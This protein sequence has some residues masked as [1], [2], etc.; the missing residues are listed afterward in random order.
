MRVLK[1]HL[2]EASVA[3]LN[4]IG[5]DS[6]TICES[7]S[8][9]KVVEPGLFV[10]VKSHDTNQWKSSAQQVR[11]YIDRLV[12]SD[13]REFDFDLDEIKICS[14]K[15]TAKPAATAIILA[16]GG[17]GRIGLDKSM[18]LINGKPIIECVY[19]QLRD[20]FSQVLISANDAAMFDFLGLE[21]VSDRTVGQGPLMAIASGLNASRNELNFVIACDIPSIDIK[22]VKKMLAQARGVD[23][24]I[25]TTADGKYEPLFAVYRKSAIEAVNN[26]LSSGGRKISDIFGHC[27]VKFIELGNKQ[28]INLNTMAEYEKFIKSE[29]SGSN[30]IGYCP[31][32][33]Y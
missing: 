2:K 16:G 3:L 8:L 25:P 6:I 29:N 21:V 33:R 28:L 30:P 26:V 11:K 27:E 17:S 13:G 15:W 20:F 7:N 10:M 23:L 4:V 9:R 18:L 14:G 1:E 24:V 19:Q 32:K 12:T 22:F 31:D 5:K